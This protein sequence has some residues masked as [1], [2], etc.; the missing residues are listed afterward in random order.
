MPH[1]AH[2]PVETGFPQVDYRGAA[3]SP[4]CATIRKTLI[5]QRLRKALRVGRLSEGGN[6]R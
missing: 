3:L 4:H 5:P 6:F 1:F 2:A